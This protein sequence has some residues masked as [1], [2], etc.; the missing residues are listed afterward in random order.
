MA[1]K[2]D[3]DYREAFLP[4]MEALLRDG[5]LLVSADREGHPGGMTFS[6]GTIGTI[7]GRPIFSV[8]V[9]HSRNT[10]QLLEATGDFTVNLLPRHLG[11]VLDLWGRTSGKEVDKWASSGLRPAS[12]RVVT[13]PIVEQGILHFECRIVS[14]HDL[15]PGNIAPELIPAYYASGDFHRVYHG[16]IVA[17]YGV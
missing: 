1:I 4:T 11:H 7:W 14:H 8:L 12:S 5:A 2:T 9:R 17:C 16:E 13:S 6:W 3:I 15:E 10:L